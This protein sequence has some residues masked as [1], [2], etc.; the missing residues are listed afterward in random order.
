MSYSHSMTTSRRAGTLA[1]IAMSGALLVS[2]SGPAS[3][4]GNSPASAS[5]VACEQPQMPE[6]A[7]SDVTIVLGGKGDFGPVA[8]KASAGHPKDTRDVYIFAS[9]GAAGVDV[10]AV[11]DPRARKNEN[12]EYRGA[13]IGGEAN[14][15]DAASAS[16]PDP[17]GDV[18]GSLVAASEL[19]RGARSIRVVV[20]AAGRHHAFGLDVGTAD[21]STDANRSALVQQ[22]VGRGVLA[23]IA[24]SVWLE[25]SGL[26]VHGSLKAGE[27]RAFYQSVCKQLEPTDVR[28]SVVTN[29][30][31]SR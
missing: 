18:I 5:V 23:P 17:V 22:L 14:C 25:F 19:G 15:A 13:R 6:V 10:L 4:A 12:E 24:D 1:A 20:P 31:T 30:E 2:C 16:A 3:G 29:K 21:L 11:I 7:G 27:L 26:D 9:P 28:C 8:A